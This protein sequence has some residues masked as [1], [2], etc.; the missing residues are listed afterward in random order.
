M[1]SWRSTD[2]EV[3]ITGN[4]KEIGWVKLPVSKQELDRICVETTGEI[5]GKDYML[6]DYN[7]PYFEI[8]VYDDLEILN[9]VANIVERLKPLE[10]EQLMNWCRKYQAGMTDLVEVGN[11]ALQ[12]REGKQEYLEDINNEEE[13]GKYLVEKIGLKNE[14]EDVRS[15][16]QEKLKL[17][18]SYLDYENIGREYDRNNQLGYFTLS[19]T[20]RRTQGYVNRNEINE[21]EYKREEFLQLDLDQVMGEEVP[22]RQKIDELEEQAMKQCMEHT[23]EKSP[24]TV[25]GQEKER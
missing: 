20:G 4:K 23:R 15:R 17:E 13:L 8:S 1:N 25:M 18:A 14:F 3:Y 9:K 11:A 10:K 21:F 2:I 7:C 24:E 19:Q 16:V 6:I 12:I 22:F 5:S